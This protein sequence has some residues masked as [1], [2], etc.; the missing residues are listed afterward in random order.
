MPR[1]TRRPTTVS[2]PSVVSP[3]ASSR[4]TAWRVRSGRSSRAST[5]PTAGTPMT[6]VSPSGREAL[7][8]MTDTAMKATTPPPR[9]A[10]T[11]NIAPSRS[12][13]V[14]TV[15]TISPEDVVAVMAG[16]VSAEW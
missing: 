13:S 7:S 5:S 9:R 1:S 16:P 11:S 3:P 12:E 15:A 2:A 10:V 14:L 8:M 4:H 6:T